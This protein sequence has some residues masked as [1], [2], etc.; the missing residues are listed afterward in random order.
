MVLRSKPALA[1][2]DLALN[3]EHLQ[4]LG[5]SPGPSFKGILEYLLEHVLERPDENTLARLE[6]LVREGGA[7]ERKRGS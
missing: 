3:G 1:V 5:L 2:S 4:A 7:R 6:A